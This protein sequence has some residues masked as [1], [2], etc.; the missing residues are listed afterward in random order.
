[1]PRRL[2]PDLSLEDLK[3]EA[4]RWLKALRAN[5]SDARARLDRALPGAPPAPTLRTIQLALAREFGLVGWTDLKQQLQLLASDNAPAADALDKYETMAR[6]L[7]EA[8]ATGTP[9]AMERLY[10]YTWHRR[11]WQ[12]MRTYVQLDLGKRPANL[13]DDVPLTIDDT[14]YL[15]ARGHGFADWTALASFVSAAPAGAAL[16]TTP[17][18][19]SSSFASPTMSSTRHAMYG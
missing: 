13:G 17:V 16:T 8:Y 19:V 5:D 14:R 12:A 7:L 2:T 6:T 3:K 4:K 15:V 10:K 18:R 9:E 1:M 11:S